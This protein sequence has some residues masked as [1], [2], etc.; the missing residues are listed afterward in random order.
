MKPRTLLILAL[1]VALLGAFIWFFERDLPGSDEL[2]EQAKKVLGGLETADVTAVEIAWEDRTVRLEKQPPEAPGEPTGEESDEPPAE[3]ESSPEERWRVV[4][5]RG[6]ESR[7]SRADR[8]EITR[9]LDQLVGLEKKRSVEQSDRGALGLEPPQVTVTLVTD[10]GERVLQVGDEIPVSQDRVVALAGGSEVFVTGGSIYGD[11]TREPR[12]WRDRN[13]VPVDREDISRV[14]LTSQQG[15]EAAPVAAPIVLVRG[16]GDLFRL[17]APL[18]DRADGDR[19]R[20]LFGDLANLRAQDFI[21]EPDDL[22]ALGLEPPRAVVEAEVSG[23][24]PVRLELGSVLDEDLGRTHGRL[25]DQVFVFQNQALAEA[26]ARPADQWRS[27]SWS[28]MRVF[29]IDSVTAQDGHGE[30]SV[31]RSGGDW[32]RGEE[33]IPYT[34]VSD[35]LYAITEAEAE[36]LLSLE[37]VRAEG[38]SLDEPTHTVIL[39]AEGRPSE[40]L[41]LYPPVAAGVPARS[42]DRKAVLLLPEDRLQTLDEALAG[43]RD[44]E[45]VPEEPAEEAVEGDAGDELDEIEITEE[46]GS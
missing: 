4:E 22:A 44:A 11:L 21:D 14:T 41:H 32:L 36:R 15:E 27:R 40:T 5:T 9:L 43:V 3:L 30:L 19:V 1:V 46:E 12:E 31:Q 26:V 25:G 8:T 38:W 20:K 10:D 35:L 42:S 18:E 2:A 29:G 7:T 37:E 13:L 33:R 6:D 24:D 16:E 28:G 34:P 23:G 17:E 39:T 45:P